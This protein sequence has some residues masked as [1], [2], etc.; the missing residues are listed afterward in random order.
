MKKY[1]DPQLETIKFDVENDVMNGGDGYSPGDVGSDE[2]GDLF[3][4]DTDSS[5][6]VKHF[7][8]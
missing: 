3:P 7:N 1:V 2:F 5:S 8:I 6:M 4:S